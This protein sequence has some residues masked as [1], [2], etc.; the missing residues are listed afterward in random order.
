MTEQSANPV[1]AQEDR[2]FR[3]MIENDQATLDRLIADD[4]HFVHSS[5]LVEDKAEFL[6]KLSTGERR[7]VRYEAVKRDVRREGGFTFVFGEANA[8][9]GRAAGNLVTKMTYT[10]VYRDLPEPRL[11][12]WHSVKSAD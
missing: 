4:L 8:E 6:R 9:I 2:R 5:G 11:L 10:A 12:A 7:Y 1:L 3:A